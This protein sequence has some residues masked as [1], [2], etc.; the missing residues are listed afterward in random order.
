MPKEN[1]IDPRNK[2]VPRYLPW[3]LGGIMLVV[4]GA[5]LNHW[6]NLQNILPVAAISGWTWMPQ[7][8]NP[9]MY[10][11]MLPFHWL[12]V[13]LVPA[14]SNI[15][16]ALCSALT[17]AVLARSVAI[18]PHDR[19]EME[20]LREPSVFSFLTGWAAWAP[21]VAAVLFAGCQLTFWENATSFSGDSFELLWFALILWQ[22][23][24]Y[25]LDER[26]GRLYFA[27]GL[28]GAGL[29]ENW[30]LVGFAPVFLMMLIWLR[31]LS[32]FNLHFLLRVTWWGLAGALV[33]L[34]VLLP[35][36]GRFS[37]AYPM[38]MW[39][40]IKVILKNNWQVVKLLG[41]GTFRH[42]L[43]LMSLTSLLPAFVMALRWSAGFGDSSRI[44]ASLVNNM[45]HGVN[46]LI[47]GVLIWVTFDPPFS[48]RHLLQDAG[49]HDAS[50]LTCY[51][52]GALCL[53]YYCG[54][55]L[56]IFGQEPIR[57]QRNSRPEPALPKS[58]AWLCP[59]IVAV[60]VATL[61]AGAGLLLYKNGPLIRS[62]NDDSLMRFAQFTAQQL[63]PAGAIVLCDPDERGK[64]YRAYLL[65]A[66]LARAGRAQLFPVVDTGSLEWTPYHNY[67]HRRFPKAWPQTLNTND[68]VRLAPP[69]ILGLLSQFYT[70]NHLC[71]INPS[72]GYYFERFYQEPHGLVYALKPLPEDTLL[73]PAL[74]RQ[75]IAENESFWK[76][77]L[78]RS[79]PAI[80]QALH[81]RD[82]TKQAGLLG[83]AMK[84]L[85]VPAESNPN[86][87]LA[88]TFY[89]RSLNFLGVQ[90]QRAGE[91]E[92]AAPCFSDAVALNSNN[93]VATINLAFNKELRAGSPSAVNLS[94]V[95]TDQ[96][97]KYRD[98]NAVVAANGP[99]DETTFCSEFGIWLMMQPTPPRL[100]RQ[101]LTQFNRVRQLAPDNLAARLFLARIYNMNYLPERALE[102]LHDPLTR[103]SRFALTESNST[104]ISVVAA[105]AHFQKNEN[106]LGAE[107]LESEMGHHPEDESLSLSSAQVFDKR[108]LYTNALRVIDRKLAKTPNDPIWLY[109]KG[110]DSLQIGAYDDA[111]AA[112]TKYLALETNNAA[113]LLDRALAYYLSDRLEAARTDLL[114]LQASHTN[115]FQAAYGLGEIARRQHQTNEA[116]RNYRIYLTNA[117]PN[118]AELNAV[119]EHLTQLGSQ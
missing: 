47:L 106:V 75:L 76:Q 36:I 12:P 112:L 40:V 55:F 48:P 23:L 37:G 33:V 92:R 50:A 5:T 80:E 21:P 79:R 29:I 119:R 90:L 71:Y 98:W 39:D 84:R 118:A 108:G 1:Q 45:M 117:P 41:Q 60:V 17:L 95:T 22:L 103:P 3:L 35:L 67:L 18:L 10:L 74:D 11:V 32:F 7:F 77:A 38:G 16:S 30:G 20:R 8:Q 64:P 82:L 99:F 89:S 53:G 34:V 102:A 51:Y 19:T 107:L 78:E 58:L 2:F 9:L 14:A 15:F 111:V 94:H 73:P 83:R 93:V 44:G 52:L 113:A 100:V 6:V 69:R 26:E 68:S 66:E 114:Q 109:G 4:Y 43:A 85:H 81:P 62:I 87:L 59:I 72:F 70:N 110:F 61:A 31:G 105:T 56:L 46:A 42:D 88:G 25:R 115:S 57:N 49:L 27:A 54:Y 28:F 97:G 91:L 65:Q 13:A 96:F 24:E 63:P 101:A 86:A 116:I 104:E